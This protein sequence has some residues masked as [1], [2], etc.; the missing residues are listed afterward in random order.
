M[1]PAGD[2]TRLL[3][4][5]AG[6][7]ITLAA[8]DGRLVARGLTGALTAED[9]AAAATLGPA[10]LA[11]VTAHACT[12]CGRHAFPEPTVCFWC[13]NRPPPAC[14]TTESHGV[15]RG[16]LRASGRR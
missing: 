4:A 2:V 9:R 12:R 3:A 11:A 7:G 15:A 13:R 1:V 10:L 5:L 6:R 16:R 14:P 8:R